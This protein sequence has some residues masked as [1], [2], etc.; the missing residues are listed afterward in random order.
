MIEKKLLD[1]E[2]SRILV[3]GG[4]GFLGSHVVEELERKGMPRDGI[5]VPRS[6]EYDLVRE[7]SVARMFRD[8][9]PDVVVHLA[10]V[11]GGIGANSARPGEFFYKNLVMGVQLMEQ[12]RLSGVRR[13]MTVGTVCSY[14]KH[15]PV[16]FREED[17]WAGY[18]EETN[19]PYGIA[20][21]ALLVQGQA[22]RQQYGFEAVHLLLVNLYGPR[23]DFDP[24]T[25]HVIPALVKKCVEAREEGRDQ[26]VV[27]GDGTPTREFLY[28]KDAAE[29]IV[30][31]LERYAD[32]EPV[33][34]GSGTEISIREL[35]EKVVE[36]TGFEGRI[37]WDDSKPNGQPRRCLDTSRARERFGF[38]ARTGLDEGLAETVQ[39]YEQARVKPIVA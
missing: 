29:G 11:V 9:R 3:T 33:N 6:A 13:F 19:A 36:V 28:V 10:A 25:S 20:K 21:K 18:P 32:P 4:S 37:E 8:T 14:P 34:I 24:A 12:A 22:Y 16:P 30:L 15:T 23:D 26:I 35:V 5:V 27:W 7:E 31:A 1:L 38:T 2:T 39:W 17:L